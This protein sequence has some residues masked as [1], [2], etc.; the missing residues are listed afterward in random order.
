MKS[1][2][3]R[4]QHH[5]PR[6]SNATNQV[7]CTAGLLKAQKYSGSE[8]LKTFTTAQKSICVIDKYHSVVK[9]FP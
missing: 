9:F 4:Q 1:I 5:Y 8:S 2:D 7:N 3:I 6:Q